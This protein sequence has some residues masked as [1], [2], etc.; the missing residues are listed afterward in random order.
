MG[1]S[2]KSTGA[3]CQALLQGIF[4]AQALNLHLLCL[5]QRQAG[6]L[7]LAAPGGALGELQD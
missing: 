4:P 1:F 3:G 5:L 7:P 2:G 6:S